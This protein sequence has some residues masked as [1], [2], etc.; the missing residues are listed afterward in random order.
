MPFDQELP[1]LDITLSQDSSELVSKTEYNS[2]FLP[3]DLA[4]ANQD[5]L[6]LRVAGINLLHYANL[7]KL[8]CFFPRLKYGYCSDDRLV[9]WEIIGFVDP[10]AITGPSYSSIKPAAPKEGKKDDDDDDNDDDDNDALDKCFIQF[11]MPTRTAAQRAMD[12]AQ[13]GKG[14]GLIKSIGSQFIL[15]SGFGKTHMLSYQARDVAFN[16]K[17]AREGSCEAEKAETNSNECAE[18]ARFTANFIVLLVIKRSRAS[19]NIILQAEASLEGEFEGALSN[20]I[21]KMTGVSFGFR[22]SFLQPKMPPG[23]LSIRPGLLISGTWEIGPL[24]FSVGVQMSF[25]LTWPPAPYGGFYFV[26]QH[27]NL[28][29]LIEWGRGI[30]DARRLR[31]GK[32]ALSRGA[33]PA[34]FKTLSFFFEGCIATEFVVFYSLADGDG[35]MPPTCDPGLAAL[36]EMKMWDFEA[37]LSY[38]LGLHPAFDAENP[39]TLSFCEGETEIMLTRPMDIFINLLQQVGDWITGGKSTLLGKAIMSALKSFFNFICINGVTLTFKASRACADRRL[40]EEIE[41]DPSG[42]VDSYLS[43]NKTTLGDENQTA[44][45]SRR[46]LGWELGVNFKVC[47]DLTILGVTFDLCFGTPKKDFKARLGLPDRLLQSLTVSCKP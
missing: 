10:V 47:F 4:H 3:R 43:G 34:F 9:G 26:V 39:A 36:L 38:A 12:R 45:S 17:G 23:K 15:F 37:S 16:P 40:E 32:P 6:H 20:P 27:T 46:Q 5:G 35:T 44:L 41:N 13:R 24:S 7:Q 14:T 29:Q 2:A 11:K 28:Y 30:T 22:V 33:I 31:K 18:D 1:S 25:S 19:L 8:V 21:I 42:F